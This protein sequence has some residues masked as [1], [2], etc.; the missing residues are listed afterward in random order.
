MSGVDVP[1]NTKILIG[2]VTS[3]A[4]SEAFAHEKLSPV[5]AMY[6]AKDF[7]DALRIADRLVRDGGFG[8][9]A[10][11]Y[12]DPV[13][14]K[15]KLDAFAHAMKACRILVNTPSSQGGIG[16]LYNFRLAPS[17]NAHFVQFLLRLGKRRR[18]ASAEHQDCCH[19]EG[20]YAVVPRA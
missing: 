1:E 7:E 19:S 16:D 12:L 11:V 15:Q 4:L 13:G 9:T 3:T 14:A 6:R 10:S 17:G 5:L 8:H 18:Q 20:K 2:E